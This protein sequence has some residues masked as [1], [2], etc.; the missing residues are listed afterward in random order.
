MKKK[1]QYIYISINWFVE[2]FKKKLKT[3]IETKSLLVDYSIA[4]GIK[5]AFVLISV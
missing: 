1:L 3:R 5:V 2:G 4:E